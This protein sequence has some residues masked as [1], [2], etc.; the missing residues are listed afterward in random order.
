MI[1]SLPLYI[2]IVFILTTAFAVLIFHYAV[3]NST[4]NRSAGTAR[5]ILSIF[6]FWLVFQAVISLNEF[7]IRDTTSIPPRFALAIIP[8]FITILILFLTKRGLVFIDNLPLL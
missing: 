8:P 7:Y 3:L 6:S 1:Q 5:I 2:T 4:S